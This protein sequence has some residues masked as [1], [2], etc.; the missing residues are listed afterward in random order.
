MI[1]MHINIDQLDDC[2][3][4]DFFYQESIFCSIV[5]VRSLNRFYNQI[6]T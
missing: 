2:A 5:V 4:S 1:A 3:L 6:I